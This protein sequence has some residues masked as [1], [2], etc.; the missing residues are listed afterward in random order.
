MPENQQPITDWTSANNEVVI[1]TA[2]GTFS[3]KAGD[4][5]SGRVSLMASDQE[6]ALTR[7]EGGATI[8]IDPCIRAQMRSALRLPEL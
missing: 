1:T 8:W 3:F 7:T 2:E 4:V 5:T 6:Q